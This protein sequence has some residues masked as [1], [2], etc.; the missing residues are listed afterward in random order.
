MKPKIN[1]SLYWTPRIL[2][3]IAILFISMFA[4][5]IF[6]NGYT[7]LET[8]IGLF[9][10]LIPSFILTIILIIAW[11]YELIGGILFLIPPI[12]YVCITAVN[13]PILMALSWSIII[14]GPF[15]IIAILFIIIGMKKRQSKSKT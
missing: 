4:L 8:I 9:M 6:G 15:I 2:A 12:I 14:G 7:F 5:D 3:I 11:K 1:K 13:V 10:H